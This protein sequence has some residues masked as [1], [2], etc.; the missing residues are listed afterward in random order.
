LSVYNGKVSFRPLI[1]AWFRTRDR[2]L[3]N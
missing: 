1:T 2:L 3:V